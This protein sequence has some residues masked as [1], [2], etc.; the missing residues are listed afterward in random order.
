MTLRPFDDPRPLDTPG[1]PRPVQGTPGEGN[2]DG[3]EREVE[4]WEA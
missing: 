1:F 2:T 3:P 4:D